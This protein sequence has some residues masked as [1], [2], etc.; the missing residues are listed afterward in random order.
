M[1]VARLVT[2]R[3]SS[4]PRRLRNGQAGSR[5]RPL[6]LDLKRRYLLCDFK[7]EFE[8]KNFIYI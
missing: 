6:A 3:V 2:G 8:K 5:R 7:K 1:F 4:P